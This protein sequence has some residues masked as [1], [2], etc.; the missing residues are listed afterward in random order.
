MAFADLVR[1]TQ[2]DVWRTCVAL[3]DAQSADDLTQETYL[4]AHR[5]LS[6]FAGD[7]SV[8][9]WL[10]SIARHVC[11]DEIRA[12]TKR[13]RVL[14]TPPPRDPFVE[15]DR[16]VDLR[17]LVAGLSPHRREAFVLTQ[18]VGLSYEETAAVLRCPVGTIRSRVARARTEL[19][20][21][22]RE[23]DVPFV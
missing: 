12:R 6:R 18:L 20:A 17:L 22:V 1:L 13:R 4:Q 14:A 8:R 2:A 16:A 23:A 21:A 10:L 11:I 15:P 9:T 19:I 5:S 7:S 3:V